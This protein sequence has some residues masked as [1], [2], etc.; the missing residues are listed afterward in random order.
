MRNR[1]LEIIRRR[2]NKIDNL[3]KVNTPKY[4]QK[5]N[6]TTAEEKEQK[7]LKEEEALLQ[8]EIK[9]RKMKLQPISSQELNKFSKEV[10]RN[11]KIFK[12]ELGMKKIQMKELW[13]ERKNLH[14]DTSD[15]L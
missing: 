5:K 12:E 2:K 14:R 10:Q 3:T 11:E 13:Q 7:R 1:E 4:I 8:I 9:K 15:L 6:Y